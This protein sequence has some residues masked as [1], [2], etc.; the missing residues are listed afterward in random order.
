[1]LTEATTTV[2]GALPLGGPPQAVMWTVSQ[3]AARDGISKQAVSR[4]VGELVA[5]GLTVERAP[6][7]NVRTVNVVEYDR[8][9]GRT[10]DPSKQ[11]RPLRADT[12]SAG[13]RAEDES[14]KE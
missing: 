12:G 2:D 13:G 7:G 6:N 3:I 11:Q 10:D 4:K 1:M 14:Y 9:R 8:L 5:S